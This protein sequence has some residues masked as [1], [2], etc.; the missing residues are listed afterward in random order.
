MYGDK[1][2]VRITSCGKYG[3]VADKKGY[4]YVE[5]H[6][7]TGKPWPAIP[8]TILALGISLAEEAGFRTFKPDTCLI[9]YYTG[10]GRLGLHQDKDEL[11]FSQPIVSI[12]LGDTC[13]FQFGGLKRTDPLKEYKLKSGDCIVFGDDDRL[14][15]HGVRK[16]VAGTNRLLPDGGRYNLTLRQ[17]Y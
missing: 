5:K 12:S 8:T 7:T 16:V 3:W 6:P 11:D 10:T 15:Y 2:N 14:A 17:V 9:N 13:V 4:H 1:F